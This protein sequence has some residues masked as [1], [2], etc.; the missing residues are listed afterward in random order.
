MDRKIYTR[1][2]MSPELKSELERIESHECRVEAA[3]FIKEAIGL[4]ANIYTDDTQA[5][6]FNPFKVEF[7]W[8]EPEFGVLAALDIR[9]D[10]MER[11]RDDPEFHRVN[12]ITS[13][14]KLRAFADDLAGI[15]ATTA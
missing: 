7:F 11:F 5:E 6:D 1:D 12:M 8:D 14:R 9:E 2:G 4:I 15:I 10:L 13:E 3:G